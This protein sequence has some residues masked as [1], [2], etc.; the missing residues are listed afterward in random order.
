MPANDVYTILNKAVTISTAITIIQV[1]AGTYGLRV[2]RITLSQKGSTVSVQEEV[3]FVRKSAAATVTAAI[4]ATDSTATI[5]KQDPSNTTAPG[6]TLSTTGTGITGSGEG[7]D[8]NTI[9]RE[10]FNVLNGLIF[11]PTPEE[12]WYIP[13]GGIGALKFPTA[14]ASQVWNA[15]VT[16]ME[17]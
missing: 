9:F 11:L 13:A 12:K 8:A 16:V 15:S 3:S 4:D 10:G 2:L 7:T 6:L 14:P 17:M 1:K 5:V